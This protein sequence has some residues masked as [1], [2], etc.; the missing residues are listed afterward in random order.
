[1]EISLND[2]LIINIKNNDN[3]YSQSKF[4]FIFKTFVKEKKY[5]QKY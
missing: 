4:Y 2:M 5:F 1:M 3:D